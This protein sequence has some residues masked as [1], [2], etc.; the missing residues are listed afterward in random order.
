[1]RDY[2]SLAH[3]RCDCKYHIVFIPKKRRNIIFGALRT[4]LGEVFH[5]LARYKG[6]VI[7]KGHLMKGYVH[8]C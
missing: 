2:K 3:T 8:I 6:V 1:M 4:H 7:E 5:E